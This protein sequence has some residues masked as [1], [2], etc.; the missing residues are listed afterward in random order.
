LIGIRNNIQEV[1]KWNS[2]H[3]EM[4]QLSLVREAAITNNR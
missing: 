3:T 2:I 1:T 4:I